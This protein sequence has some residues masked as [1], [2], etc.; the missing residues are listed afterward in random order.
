MPRLSQRAV[1]AGWVAPRFLYLHK[2]GCGNAA[3]SL[4]RVESY[5]DAGD[6]VLGIGFNLFDGMLPDPH[7]PL[8]CSSCGVPLMKYGEPLRR[9]FV[10]PIS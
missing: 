7:W 2:D 1:D 6:L 9:E 10:V 4:D 3:F 8:R 5:G